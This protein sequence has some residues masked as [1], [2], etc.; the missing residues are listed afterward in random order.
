MV[1]HLKNFLVLIKLELHYLNRLVFLSR[2]DTF[3]QVCLTELNE[4]AIDFV[5]AYSVVLV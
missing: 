2:S 5:G 3:D 1:V 4:F